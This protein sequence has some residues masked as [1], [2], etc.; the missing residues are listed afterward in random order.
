[1][2]VSGRNP[3]SRKTRSAS[4][5]GDAGLEAHGDRAFLEAV[6]DVGADPVVDGVAQGGPAVHEGHLRSRP[7]ELEGGDGGGVL[8]DDDDHGLP[9]VGV[10][11]G[12]VVRHVR[13]I[14]AGDPEVDGI[15]VVP[16]GEDHVAGAPQGGTAPAAGVHLEPGPVG[17]RPERPHGR[18][19][20]AQRHAQPVGLRHPAVVL[21]ALG[22]GRLL[23]GRH[24][25]KT[26]DLEQLGGGER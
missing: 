10:R 20:L 19:L 22:L 3:V 25:G 9:E 24:E 15:V 12:V 23:E 5:L 8:A 4:D 16:G 7:E 6:L 21:E 11:L 2:R 14:L 17:G 18:D 26:A 13:P 1:M